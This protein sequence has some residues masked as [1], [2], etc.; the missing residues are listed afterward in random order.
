MPTLTI[1]GKEI[2]VE[3]G[4]T[5]MQACEKLGVDIPRY[6]YHPGLP[7][8]GNCRICLVDIEKVPRPQI[9]CYT[10]CG[11]NMVVSTQSDTVKKARESVLE[12]LLVNH[13]LDCP[14]CDQAGECK[15]QNYYMEYGLYDSRLNEDKN[16]KHKAVSIGPTIML[17][18]ERCILCSRCV[19]FT[20]HI[21][22]TGEFGIFNRGDHS[23]VGLYPGKELDNDY[24]GN[25]AD[26][27]PVGAL[28]DKDFRFK[29]RVWYL[30]ETPSVCPGCSK[31]CNIDVHWQT[32]RPHKAAGDRVMRLKP[33]FNADVNEW[34]ICDEGRYG[35][36]RVDKERIL[37]PQIRTVSTERTAEDVD[38]ERALDTLDGL[39]KQ[40][41]KDEWL[42]LVSPQ[43]T[44]EDLYLAKRLFVDSLGL[45]TYMLSG[46]PEGKQDDFL[47]RADK[48][49]NRKGALALEFQDA[50]YGGIS[51]LVERVRQGSFKGL[52][53]FGQ[54]LFDFLEEDQ[55]AAALDALRA[56][57]F[58]GSNWNKTAQLANLILPGA[59][60]AEKDGT[61]TNEAGRVQRL[62]KCFEP[63][64]EARADWEI[65]QQI[66]ARL[67]EA[68]P[69]TEARE[70]FQDIAKHSKPFAGL[71]YST[72]KKQG[73]QLAC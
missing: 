16:K 58:Q 4:T 24:S 9:A 66:Q 22:K 13:P 33:R 48:N 28:T 41:P 71:T 14:V 69:Y 30:K 10:P 11:D 5:I 49:P 36:S 12:F 37:S 38:W 3:K 73:G 1:D 43:L 67:G 54:D 68:W 21:T 72:L 70:V 8:S 44:N 47:M 52:Y 6:C 56:V 57:V 17:D 29:C 18:S 31:G 19:R 55:A 40:I 61:F 15:L 32:D 60:Y 20:D 59:A 25:V 51:E 27:C 35:Y 62:F 64:A 39:F 65:L 42:V 34:W 45:S 53:L 7:V 26:I 46:R 50:S 2:T 63:M 23:E